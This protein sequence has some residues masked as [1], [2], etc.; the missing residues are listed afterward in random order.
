MDNKKLSGREFT[1]NHPLLATMGDD[2][3]HL[4]AQ[5]T[6][7]TNAL[8][9][10]LRII[11]AA[12]GNESR[13][14]VAG[15]ITKILIDDTDFE[16]VSLLFYDKEHD[17]LRLNR[18]TGFLDAMVEGIELDYNKDLVFKRGEG[19]VWQV[20]ES[21]TPLFIEDCGKSPLPH[22]E[23]AKI[24]PGC[25]VCLP[26]RDQG[27]INLSS[28]K[29]KGL[30]ETKKRCLTILGDLI[31]HLLRSPGLQ[32]LLDS[33]HHNLQQLVEVSPRDAQNTDSEPKTSIAYLKSVMQYVPQGVCI[34]DMHGNINYAN[35]RLLH[36]LNCKP[37]YIYARSIRDIFADDTGYETFKKALGKKEITRLSGVHLSMA[38]GPALPVEIFLHPLKDQ[39]GKIDGVMLI[40]YDLST[41][42]SLSEGML[43]D[44]KLKAIGT[45]AGGVAHNF[46]NLLTAILGNIELLARDI[47]DPAAIKRIKNIE[48]AVLDGAQMIR[49]LQAF[50]Q[51]RKIRRMECAQ[52]DINAVIDDVIELTSPRW[53]DICQ[54]NGIRINLTKELD[55]TEPASIPQPELKEVLINMVFNAIDA[56]PHGGDITMR[57]YQRGSMVFIEIEDTGLGMSNETKKQIFDP[58]FSTKGVGNSGLGLSVS[59]GLI[60]GSGGD[61]KVRSQE[62]KGTTFILSLPV[63]GHQK[64]NMADDKTNDPNIKALKVLVVDDDAQIVDLL[65]SMLS[66]MAHS[67]TGVSN[68]EEALELIKKDSFDLII[69]DLGMPLVNGWQI[70]EA[71]RQKKPPVPVIL[72]TGWGPDYDGE[73]LKAHGVDAV[74]CKPFKFDT[75]LS[76]ITNIIN[77]TQTGYKP[78]TCATRRR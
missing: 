34:I 56:M 24:H 65:S 30:S 67:V 72:L 54:K 77:Q 60:V 17:C 55:K 25:L 75:L 1:A 49:R 69:T 76:T 45:M 33:G 73:D 63:A 66:D 61:I 51:F 44:E 70:A 22:K 4:R 27:V 23:G 28:S 68:G 8:G 10:I 62:G 3:L 41:S 16:N 64:F 38:G 46:N 20:F 21:Q 12:A 36:M 37:A 7:A 18:A 43:R 71:A 59:Y 5:K 14:V 32:N 74:L 42:Q 11:Q 48:R 39:N 58:F 78:D 53:K 13:E 29:E 57:A 47:A 15:Y 9:I 40:I 52:A 35:Q 2:F 6:E 50:T 26:L 31:G 19:I